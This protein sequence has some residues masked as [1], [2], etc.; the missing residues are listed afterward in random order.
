MTGQGRFRLIGHTA[1]VGLI[2]DGNSLAEAY[3]AAAR[4]M[5]AIITDI[6]KVRGKESRRVTVTA[7]DREGLLFEWL[8]HFLYLFDVEMMVFSRFDIMEL[9]EKRLTAEA[10]GEKFDPSRHPLKTGV[11]SATYHLLEVDGAQHRVRVIFDV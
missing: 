9:G 4:G 1:D 10:Y 5:F 8:N 11:K 6:R 2:A 3:A 7:D